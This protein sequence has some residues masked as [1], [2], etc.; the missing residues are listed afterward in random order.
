M[1]INSVTDL[2]NQS[3][4]QKKELIDE[5]IQTEKFMFFEMFTGLLVI[6]INGFRTKYSEVKIYETKKHE[7]F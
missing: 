5:K 6:R 3:N 4:C 1:Y 2:I 7:I